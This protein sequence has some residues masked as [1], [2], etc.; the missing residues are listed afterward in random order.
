LRIAAQRAAAD[1]LS[2]TVWALVCDGA[3][4]PFANAAFDAIEHSDVLCCLEAKTSV[5]SECRRVARAASRM[6]FSVIS[7]APSL[8]RAAH[9]RTVA[10]GPPF[11]GVCTAYGA[12]LA[13]A[14]WEMHERVDLTA[15]YGAA[16]RRRVSEEEANAAALVEI[17]GE[18]QIAEKLAQR[19][20]TAA[21][22]DD[23]LLVRE[24]FSA[25]ACANDGGAALRSAAATTAHPPPA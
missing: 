24:L 2:C 18:A 14:G 7:I 22:I 10:A 12:M 4:M 23:G 21:A 20:R 16:V 1:R 17:L 6:V 25:R 9:A 13:K 15:A 8:S 5:L 11:K 3:A 19:R